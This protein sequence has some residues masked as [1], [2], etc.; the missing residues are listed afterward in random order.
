MKFLLF[1]AF[2]LACS[3]ISFGQ[4]FTKDSGNKDLSFDSVDLKILE[5]ADIILSSEKVW[6]REDDRK[7]QDDIEKNNYS[8]FCALYKASI[9]VTGAY[10]HRRPGLQQVRWII[11]EL[12]QDR[13]ESHRLMDYNNHEKTNFEEV[14]SL[15]M[16]SK[17]IVQ[18]KILD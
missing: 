10:E 16:E 6:N 4:T 7:C 15:L 12:Y 1:I 8:L 14:K 2:T 17:L 11:G 18:Q 13:L 3:G 5:K 9:D